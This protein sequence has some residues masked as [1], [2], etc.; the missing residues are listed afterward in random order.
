V[1]E[2]ESWTVDQLARDHELP[3]STVRLYQSRG[4]LP[5]PRKVGRVGF[6][7]PDHR[8]RLRLIGEL[9]ERGFSLA[10][11]KE[12]L[13]GM[14]EGRSLAA[15]LRHGEATG[16]WVPEAPERLSLQELM[17]RLPDVEPT[18]ELLGRITDLGLVSF[19]DDGS[20]IV[21]SPAFLD[22]GGALMKMGVSTDAVL[23]E[24]EHLRGLTDDVATRFTDVF[25]RFF[26]EQF[27]ADG[28]PAD[29]LSE[30]VGSLEQLGPLAESVV[31]VAL[32]HS[33]QQA[34]EK[35]IDEQADRLGIEIPRPG[36]Q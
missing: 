13:D 21:N 36:A 16:T 10:A 25:L 26:W 15:V 6:Y 31:T 7:G 19:T 18:P 35:F 4:L 5:A 14:A 12:L 33:L 30:L 3:V 29:R 28:L 27:E 9:Q 20:V 22:I 17:D 32:R 24:Y 1:S 34:A 8:Q 23:D 2:T 11:I